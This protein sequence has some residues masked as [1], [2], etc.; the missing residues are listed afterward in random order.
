MSLT[1]IADVGRGGHRHLHVQL[2]FEHI[3]ATDEKMLES[4]WFYLRPG[5]V[6]AVAEALAPGPAIR[7]RARAL[8][9]ERYQNCGAL[10]RVIAVACDLGASHLLFLDIDPFIYELVWR[11]LPIPISGVWFR[12]N[13]HYSEAG[14]LH[15][16]LRQRVTAWVKG[17]VARALCGREVIRRIFVL[18]PCAAEYATRHYGSDKIQFLPDPL[19]YPTKAGRKTVSVLDDRRV[20]AIVGAISRRKGMLS[21]LGALRLLTPAMQRRVELRIVGCAL[22][23]ERAMLVDAIERTREST[24]T[25]VSWVDRFVSDEAI[26]VA[27]A[28]SDVLLLLYQRF[29]GSSGLLIRAALHGRPVVATRYGL[30]GAAVSRHGLGITIDPYDQER[31]ARSITQAVSGDLNY[32]APAAQRFAS[33]CSPEHYLRG[34]YELIVE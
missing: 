30:I 5:T 9:I 12:P 19:A 14:Y 3:L 16:G 17:G 26:D 31:I 15:E 24:L 28:Q 22:E 18:D 23:S 34:L 27:I 7:F 11:S 29:I 25:R 6:Q 32:D 2:L 8:E 4:L 13:F 21:I 1:L 20:F 10:E 33:M